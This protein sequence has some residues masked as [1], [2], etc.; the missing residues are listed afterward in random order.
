MVAFIFT[1]IYNDLI[2]G[3]FIFQS[4]SKRRFS[5]SSFSY[6]E[7][8]QVGLEGKTSLNGVFIRV[9]IRLDIS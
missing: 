1:Q 2:T 9:K 8:M 6:R 7:R 4:V 3:F 5:I